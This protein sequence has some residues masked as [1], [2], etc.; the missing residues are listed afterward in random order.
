MTR[1]DKP[2]TEFPHITTAKR[3]AAAKDRN[4]TCQ[5]FLLCDRPAVCFTPHPVLGSVPTCQ[6][7]H[8]FATEK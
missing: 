7:C 3:K 8:D 5:W 6:R 1:K 4:G 2:L